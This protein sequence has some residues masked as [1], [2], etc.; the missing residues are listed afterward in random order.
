V[1]GTLVRLE[2]LVPRLEAFAARLAALGFLSTPWAIALAVLAVFSSVPGRALVA[3][4]MIE[5]GSRAVASSCLPG[6]GSALP[7]RSARAELVARWS[8]PL[9]PAALAAQHVGV[10]WRGSAMRASP[11]F[12]A[13]RVVRRG[14]RV[15]G[16]TFDEDATALSI[17]DPVATQMAAFIRCCRLSGMEWSMRAFRRSR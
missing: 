14:R 2:A 4:P 12:A 3:G 6:V 10:A 15:R 17:G 9:L 5:T 1:V 13:C 11:L 7:R 16:D 8:Q